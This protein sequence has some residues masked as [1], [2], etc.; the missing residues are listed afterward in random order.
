MFDANDALAVALE[1]NERACAIIGPDLT[2]HGANAAFR[3]LA[4][5]TASTS[6]GV[7]LAFVVNQ[8]SSGERVLAAASEAVGAGQSLAPPGF[9]SIGAWRYQFHPLRQGAMLVIEGAESMPLETALAGY[10]YL[11]EAMPLVVW[12]ARPDGMLDYVSGAA[13]RFVTSGRMLLGDAWEA[14]V[15]PDD[16]QETLQRWS[17]SVAVGDDYV[18]D[19]RLLQ[20]DGTYRWMR[21]V[22]RP[23]RSVDRQILRWIGA[24]MEINDPKNA[25]SDRLRLESRYRALVLAA[26]AVAYVCDASGRFATPQLSWER[27]T[28]Q[29]WDRHNGFGWVEMVHPDDCAAVQAALERAI[30]A[31]ELYRADVRIWH[32]ASSTFRRC[33]IRAAGT[34]GEEGAVYEWVGMVTDVEESLQTAQS[35][36]EE[37][38]R[39]DLSIDAA[40]VGTFHCPMPLGR[41]IWNARCKEHFWLPPTAEVDF[42][43]FYAIIHPED[44]EKTR[45]AVENAVKKGIPYD[46]EYRT[47]SPEGNVRWIRAKGS[48]YLD[49]RGEPLRFDGITIDISRQKALELERNRLLSMERLQRVEAQHGSRLRDTFLANVSHELRTPLN[50][51]QSWIYLLRRESPTADVLERGLEAVERN[52]RLQSRLVDDLLDVSRVSAGKLFIE[53]AEMDLEQLLLEEIADA[54][55][56]A[57]SKR[58]AIESKLPETLMIHADSI[59]LRQVFSNL[60]GNALK[61]TDAG[62]RVEVSARRIGNQAEVVVADNGAGIAAGFI[63]HVFEPFA[64][65]GDGITRR[66]GG[67]GIGLTIAKR[68]VDLHGGSITVHSAGEGKGSQFVVLLPAD[69]RPDDVPA[70]LGVE[71]PDAIARHEVLLDGMKILLVEDEA[72][73]RE[74]M[75]AVL[76]SAGADVRGAESAAAARQCLATHEVDVILSDIGMPDEDGYSLIRSLRR[77]GMGTPAIAVTA[78]GRA[79]DRAAALQAGFGLHL[80]KPVDPATLFDAIRRSTLPA[81]PVRTQDVGSG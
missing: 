39:L 80:A 35:L 47:V 15:H 40:E 66:H 10:R 55:V 69:D 74:A 78:F 14:L 43:R 38:E 76:A 8:W 19:H 32:A 81:S 42:A 7:P 57:R 45:A 13:E 26:S 52:V 54:K 75:T 50:A 77:D 70:T 41:I 5:L 25:R 21:S 11:S 64:Q 3:R 58:I 6:R 65:Y 46:I 28:G 27:Y 37:R 71:A 20:K 60:V 16:L 22:A 79:E 56:T 1:L 18:V 53:V 2:I 67:L 59:R 72:D 48:T 23:V 4:G 31:D 63:K 34:R 30:A 12:T 29:P 49:E 44:R 68:I 61:Y 73:A 36:R 17:A 9:E 33:Q 62:G 51:M 24:T